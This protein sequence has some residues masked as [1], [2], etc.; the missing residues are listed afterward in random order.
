MTSKDD[1]TLKKQ[2]SEEVQDMISGIVL[3]NIP[4][5]LAWNLY[6]EGTNAASIGMYS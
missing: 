1:V 3:L 5:E 4:N 2:L 6:I